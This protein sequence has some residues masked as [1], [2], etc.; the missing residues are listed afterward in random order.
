MLERIARIMSY[1]R[2]T[3]DGRKLKKKDRDALLA[4]GGSGQQVRRRPGWAGQGSSKACAWARASDG[5]TGAV[6]F[7]LGRRRAQE[8][9]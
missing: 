3:A 9:E 4:A 8:L 5:R 7:G 6:W 1:V 2:T